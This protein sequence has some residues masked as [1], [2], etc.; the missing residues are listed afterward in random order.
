[1]DLISLIITLVV[2]GVVLWLVNTY[3][4]MQ[5][6]IKKILNVAVII[7]VILWLLFT[8][9]GLSNVGRVGVH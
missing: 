4:P 8:V 5:P 2:V 9:L 7:L 6:S 1:M 3:V